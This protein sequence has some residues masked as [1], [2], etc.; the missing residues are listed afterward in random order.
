MIINQ[1]NCVYIIAIAYIDKQR[2]LCFGSFG[3]LSYY[4]EDN[5]KYGLLSKCILSQTT[6]ILVG[7]NH[8]I[9]INS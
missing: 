2:I 5:G 4:F 3:M 7:R 6:N 1:E 8:K 9:K